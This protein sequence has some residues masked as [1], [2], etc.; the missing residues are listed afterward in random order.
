MSHS[1]V[2]HSRDDPSWRKF[3][4]LVA[5][6]EQT[7]AGK[8]AVVTTPDHVPDVVTSQLREV[9][10]S[11]RLTV[12]PTPI[13]IT[14][15]SRKRK[16]KQDVRWIEELATK[17]TNIGAA[18]TIAVSATG[19]TAA[20]MEAAG[21]HGIELRTLE[22][23]IGEEIVQQFLSGFKISVIVTDAVARTI[24]FQLED[25]RPL[26]PTDLGDDL[27]AALQS[28]GDATSVVIATEVATG[29]GLTLDH[30]LQRGDEGDIPVDG[31]P[32]T[33]AVQVGF[34]PGR[35]FTVSTKHGPRLVGRVEVLAEYKRSDVPAPTTGL[36]EYATVDRP[37]RRIIEAVGHISHTQGVR[38]LVDIDSPTLERHDR[39]DS[40]PDEQAK[41]R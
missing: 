1:R 3:Q 31:S 8:G 4:D 21:R 18:K 7:L 34:K 38:L 27:V 2:K 20:A 33:K 19:F 29:R 35:A 22:D 6:I 12:G 13:L 32:I 11:I 23:R 41:G 15:E 16:P 24:A 28:G 37:L 10:A 5:H 17:K 39:D 26:L 25:G 9:D 40:R 30:I 14:V 36:Y